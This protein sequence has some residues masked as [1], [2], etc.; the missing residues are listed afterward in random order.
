MDPLQQ[1]I[2]NLVGEI[3]PA[4][5]MQQSLER[6]GSKYWRYEDIAEIAIQARNHIN[7]LEKEIYQLR[8]VNEQM[9]GEMHVL[10][11]ELQQ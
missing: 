6:L 11:M 5:N 8:M 10:R 7:P 4:K 1:Q 2:A 3:L 9:R